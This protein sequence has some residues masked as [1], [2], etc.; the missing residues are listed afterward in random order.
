MSFQLH[1]GIRGLGVARERIRIY[2]Q[3][4]ARY[5]KLFI[6]KPSY[7][8]KIR[9]QYITKIYYICQYFEG[10]LSYYFITQLISYM[11][12][13]KNLLSIYSFLFN[14]LTFLQT[15]LIYLNLKFRYKYVY[16]QH[17]IYV[18][19]SLTIQHVQTSLW[20]SSANIWD[21]C[22]RFSFPL[23]YRVV[24]LVPVTQ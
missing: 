9:E 19:N 10:Y 16:K 18:I 1:K 12:I 14:K 4:Q 20:V 22:V 8:F 3:K 2:N 17:Q 7:K 13:S 24:V 23:P 11:F 5:T 21:L 15:I 6:C